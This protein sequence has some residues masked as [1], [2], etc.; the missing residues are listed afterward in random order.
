MFIKLNGSWSYQKGDYAVLR[1]LSIGI[2]LFLAISISVVA[3]HTSE[4]RYAVEQSSIEQRNILFTENRLGQGYVKPLGGYG[5][6][7]ASRG[8]FGS[9]GDEE[10]ALNL[11]TD[12][13][14]R[15]GRN[16]GHISNYYS[17]ARGYPIMN[18]YVELKPTDL[19]LTSRPQING[20]PEGYAR[21]ISK[22]A[23]SSSLM[24]GT[25]LLRTKDLPLLAPLYMYEAWLLDEDTGMSMSLGVF[26]PAPV[27]RI[28]TLEYTS[29]TPL[30]AFETII[31]TSEPFPDADPSPG[32][33]VLA[34]NLNDKMVRTY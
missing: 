14:I 10:S 31:V 18:I 22:K 13:F 25:V 16:P 26:Q 5:S 28:A 7:S 20:S 9:K 30:N 23:W 1:K 27:G 29:S 19:Q 6:K 17:S 4:T 21:V 3:I 33:I 34:G 11:A 8:S 15:Q 12:S 32:Q 24:Q 2:V